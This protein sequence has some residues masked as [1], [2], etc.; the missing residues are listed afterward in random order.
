MKTR[1]SDPLKHVKLSSTKLDWARLIMGL[2]AGTSLIALMYF[3]TE[4]LGI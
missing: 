3:G 1:T 2:G 4:I